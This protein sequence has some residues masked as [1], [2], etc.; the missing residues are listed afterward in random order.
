MGLSIALQPGR[1]L[2]ATRRDAP[3]LLEPFFAPIDRS[4]D[5]ALDARLDDPYW[6][7]TTRYPAYVDI[8]VACRAG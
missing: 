2:P 6:F 5:R 4:L 3:E 8:R 1:K 7:D